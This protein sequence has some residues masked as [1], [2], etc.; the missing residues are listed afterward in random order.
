MSTLEAAQKELLTLINYPGQFEDDAM[1]ARVEELIQTPGIDLNKDNFLLY[2]AERGNVRVG[3]ALMAAG[4]NI[5]ISTEHRNGSPSIRNVM[6]Y[7]LSGRFPERDKQCMEFCE[8]MRVALKKAVTFEGGEYPAERD[9]FGSTYYAY[10]APLD[11]AVRGGNIDAV[12]YCLAHGSSPKGTYYNNEDGTEDKRFETRHSPINM[13]AEGK[14][15]N[16]A[17]IAKILIEAGANPNYYRPGFPNMRPIDHALEQNNQP[18]INA[19][20]SI[21]GIDLTAI[22]G[23]PSLI[24]LAVRTGN[25]AAVAALLDKKPGAEYHFENDDRIDLPSI[26]ADLSKKAHRAELDRNGSDAYSLYYDHANADPKAYAKIHDLLVARGAYECEEQL[27]RAATAVVKDVDK[28]TPP[29]ATPASGTGQ[30]KVGG[31][32]SPQKTPDRR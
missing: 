32:V 12:K 23:R 25:V 20:L 1:V 13:L 30:G 15:R 11:E 14:G 27:Y 19:L 22:P 2:S 6:D 10:F 4:A 26:A 21:P 16:A 31:V 17:E 7:A 3:K 24:K 8:M 18:V 29:L 5:F 9:N 28:I